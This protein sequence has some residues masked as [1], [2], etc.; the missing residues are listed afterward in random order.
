MQYR[1]FLLFVF[2]ISLM[3]ACAPLISTRQMET[4]TMLTDDETKTLGSLRK[5]DDHPLYTMTYYGSYDINSQ[6]A[7]HPVQRADQIS[8][9]PWAC[10]LFASMADPDDLLYGRNFDW[11]PSPALL[12]F[13]DPPNGYASGSMVDISY[14]GFTGSDADN[15][16]SLPAS[17]LTALLDAPYLPFDGMNETGLAIGMAA[18]PSGDFPYDPSKPTVDSLLIM[19]LILDQA[20]TVAEAVGIFRTYNIDWGG[21]PPVHYL[22]ADASGKAV[23]VEFTATE[24]LVIPNTQPWHLA[25]NFQVSET[26]EHPQDQCWRYD[27]VSQALNSAGGSLAPQDALDI[28]QSVSQPNTQWS[29]VYSI[30][31]RKIG[32]VMGRNYMNEHVFTLP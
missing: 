9:D 24:M 8:S 7:I 17:E 1:R 12:L 27:L 4:P 21:G 5:S 18:V 15:L 32:V 23:L 6:I 16:T 31:Q 3:M 26:G 22:I 10:T 11:D 13:T 14:L 25:T 28:L 29:I 2:L 20:A 30:S 19:R